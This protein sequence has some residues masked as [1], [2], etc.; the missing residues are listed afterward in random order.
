MMKSPEGKTSQ[1]FFGGEQRGR[2]LS[3]KALKWF[4]I[5][6]YLGCVT[7]I[8]LVVVVGL[9][10]YRALNRQRKLEKW[11][12][13]TYKVLRKTDS[14]A[15]YFNKTLLLDGYLEQPSHYEK[16]FFSASEH[17]GLIQQVNGLIILLKDNRLR[18]TEISL[19]GRQIDTLF[20]I[21][22]E[23]D[24]KQ[25]REH[26]GDINETLL[27]IKQLEESLLLN[28]ESA[29]TRS[30]K[31]TQ[32]IIVVGSLLILLIVSCLIYVILTELKSRMRAYQE[33]HE[34]NQLK[35]SFIT[36]ASHEF[37]TPLSSVLLS[38]TLIERYL[39]RN[40]SGPA[41][42]HA[43][44]IRQVVHNLESILED[45]LSLDQL[46]EGLIKAEFTSFDLV[47]LCR[48]AMLNFRL[49]AKPGQQLVYD[50]PT[51]PQMVNLDS[52][53][54]EKSL[55]GLISNA[56]K[57]AGDNAHICLTTE[58]TAN[59]V[60]ISVKDNGLGIAEEGQKKLSTLFY[61]VDSTG[62]IAGTGL[63]LNIVKRYVQLMGGTLGFSSVPNKQTCFTMTFPNK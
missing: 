46:E 43:E 4:R 50:S 58:V 25:F 3:S 30:S 54:I 9:I 14:I 53:L 41:L 19:L 12:E 2:A 37:R 45:F 29:Y 27:R 57:Y 20:R 10:S 23:G 31:Q 42:K 49:T 7:S 60:I 32:G 48:D 13:H 17:Q 39:E 28:R 18:S 33:E 1:I 11:V 5:F 16:G 36:L 8:V 56:I 15:M 47:Q 34:L 59:S 63:G 22:N 61:R 21:S 26:I 38:A 51:E 55:S 44:K 6:F 40:E 24:T 52:D 35:S 62:N